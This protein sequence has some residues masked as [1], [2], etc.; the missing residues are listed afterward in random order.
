MPDL[1]KPEDFQSLPGPLTVSV[2]IGDAI[3]N[4]E[5]IVLAVEPRPP[6]R[7]REA[8]FSLTLSG[9]RNPLLPQGTYPVRHPQ[10][11]VIQLFLVPSDQDA[12][13]TQYAVTFN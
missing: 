8:P 2:K 1:L 11:G 7:Y 6:H 3:T 4:V 5:L 13:S 9:P 10:L 12:Q